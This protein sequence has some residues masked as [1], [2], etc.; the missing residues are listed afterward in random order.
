MRLIPQKAIPHVNDVLLRTQWRDVLAML[1][2][3]WHKENELINYVWNYPVESLIAYATLISEEGHKR[4]FNFDANKIFEKEYIAE[5]VEVILYTTKKT[6]QPIFREHNSNYLNLFC[7]RE[8]LAGTYYWYNFRN[9]KRPKRIIGWLEELEKFIKFNP[10]AKKEQVKAERD[11]LYKQ[12]IELVKFETTE[13]FSY[14]V[15]VEEIVEEI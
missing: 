5:D 10:G 9:V 13:S 3:S 2:K 8:E 6:G 1:G 14:N 11:K 15:T 4:K 7:V 12:Y